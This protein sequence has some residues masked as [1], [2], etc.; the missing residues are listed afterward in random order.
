MEGSER[1]QAQPVTLA[2][3]HVPNV[4]GPDLELDPL[5]ARLPIRVFVLADVLL[6]ERVDVLVGA[7]RTAGRGAADLD[8]V[9]RVAGL[10]HDDAD[11]RV[12]L[13]VRR[14]HPADGAV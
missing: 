14:P 6:G 10:E 5:L 13:E 8:E 9:I 7:V 3:L 1:V 4:L 2:L 11:P 12:P